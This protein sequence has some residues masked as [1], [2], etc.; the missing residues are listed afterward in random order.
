[1][2][3]TLKYF[4]KTNNLWSIDKDF[5]IDDDD[6]IGSLR[7]PTV[8]REKFKDIYCENY[9]PIKCENCEDSCSLIKELFE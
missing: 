4:N 8:S 6:L 1:M 9:C 7:I 3:N 5:Y 2:Y